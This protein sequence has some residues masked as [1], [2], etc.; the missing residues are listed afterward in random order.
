MLGPRHPHPPDAPHH[1]PG[2][3]QGLQPP[4]A[5]QGPPQGFQPP[6]APQGPPQGFQPPGAPQQQP[7]PP[8]HPPHPPGVA[9]QPPYPPAM[10]TQGAQGTLPQITDSD[11]QLL[12]ELLDNEDEAQA[13]FL[14]LQNSPP[15]I[16]ALGYLV[17]RAFERS[18]PS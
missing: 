14:M 17:L 16:A 8:H 1:P 3:P 15:E 11:R 13:L 6:G 10:A 4:G 18:R 9:H 5:P 12:G 2:A 7:H